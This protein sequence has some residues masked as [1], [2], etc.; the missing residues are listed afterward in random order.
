VHTAPSAG[1][2]TRRAAP[3]A[4]QVRAIY[5]GLGSHDLERVAQVC[6]PDVVVHL[7]GSH[8]L[9]GTYVGAAAVRELFVRIDELGG[10]GVFTITSL[11]ADDQAAAETDVLLVE[12]CVAHG[13]HVRM[14]VH[15]LEIRHPR[16]LSLHEHPMDQAAENA[17]W[18]SR[19]R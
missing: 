16:Q 5:A 9:S 12:A 3:V 19:S 18:S 2:P 4:E 17:F 1:T 11:M 10:P 13:R 8:P 6:R 15:R 14:I 7:A